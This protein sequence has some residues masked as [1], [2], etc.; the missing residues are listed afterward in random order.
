MGGGANAA[1]RKGQ[2]G[3]RCGQDR[4]GKFLLVKLDI[5]EV[6]TWEIAFGKVSNITNSTVIFSLLFSIRKNNILSY[7]FDFIE[8]H[9]NI[10]SD[11]P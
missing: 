9:L 4:L 11:C 10:E 3:K 5:W 1:A 8:T 6:A 7:F 2:G